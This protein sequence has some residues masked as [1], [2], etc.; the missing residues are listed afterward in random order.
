MNANNTMDLLRLFEG[1]VSA[2]DIIY[3]E[4]SSSISSMLTKERLRR[5]M[6][7]AEFAQLLNVKQSQVSKWESGDV[8]FSLKVIARYMAAL[9]LFPDN[10]Y[11]RI[12]HERVDGG[13]LSSASFI[14]TK[15]IA[16]R[17]PHEHYLNLEVK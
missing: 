12:N 2:E 3:S 16:F 1:S 14:D 15:V 17:N 10:S 8:N 7:Q 13:L 6:T 11:H 9:G 4:L 5:N